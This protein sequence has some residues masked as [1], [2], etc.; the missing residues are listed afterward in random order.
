MLSFTLIKNTLFASLI[1]LASNQLINADSPV[2][3]RTDNIITITTPSLKIQIE[4][5]QPKWNTLANDIATD[6]VADTTS[7]AILTDDIVIDN[8]DTV[9]YRDADSIEENKQIRI[10]SM[11]PQ[12]KKWI[13]VRVQEMSYLLTDLLDELYVSKENH[14]EALA[15]HILFLNAY[16]ELYQIARAQLPI[17]SWVDSKLFSYDDYVATSMKYVHSWIDWAVKMLQHHEE[18]DDNFHRNKNWI[19]IMGALKR[20]KREQVA[21]R[22]ISTKIEGILDE[23]VNL[24]TRNHWMKAAV[25]DGLKPEQIVFYKKDIEKYVAKS[26]PLIYQYTRYNYG[27]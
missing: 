24:N 12:I 23:L 13:K 11:S 17:V 14:G 16:V 27:F 21:S 22:D 1:V 10:A 26:F 2:Q 25:I 15:A 4:E 6:L 20:V 19:N 9:V 7:R 5:L 18:R 8:N 3:V